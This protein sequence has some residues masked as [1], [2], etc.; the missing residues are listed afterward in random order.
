[1]SHWGEAPGPIQDTLKGVYLC[2]GCLVFPKE[3]GGSVWGGV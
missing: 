3:D 2:A 1:M